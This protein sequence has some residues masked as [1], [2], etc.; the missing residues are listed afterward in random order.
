MPVFSPN[1]LFLKIKRLCLS[2]TSVYIFSLSWLFFAVGNI[3]PS[4]A[5]VVVAIPYGGCTISHRFLLLRLVSTS[6]LLPNDTARQWS[7]TTLSDL[8]RNIRQ[9]GDIWQPMMLPNL[10]HSKRASEDWLDGW[11]LFVCQKYSIL[12]VFVF[13]VTIQIGETV[14]HALQQESGEITAKHSQWMMSL[15][16]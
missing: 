5:F 15:Q 2:W 1:I 11:Y 13:Y 16:E 9:A 12:I 14:L 7:S 3:D 6:Y 10:M 4:S 8:R